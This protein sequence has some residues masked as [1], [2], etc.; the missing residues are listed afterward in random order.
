MT[1]QK[2]Q[3]VRELIEKLEKNGEVIKC[4]ED[5]IFKSVY[6]DKK[7]EGILSYLIVEF[8]DLEEEEVFGNLSIVDSYEPVNNITNKQNTHDLKVR[9]KNNSIFL[10]A[11]QFNDPKTR[12]RNSAHYHAGIVNQIK[13]N[14]NENSIGKVYQI[15]FDYK[16]PFSDEL[17]SNIMM[18]DMKTHQ[19]DESEKNFQKIK[20]NLSKIRKLRYNDVSKLSK[21]EKI[22]LIM[23]ENKKITLHEIAK[24]DKELEVMVGKLEDLSKDPDVMSYYD[25]QKLEEMGQRLNLE[26]AREEGHR[27]TLIET[28]KKMLNKHM[29]ID[30]IIDI[31]NLTKEEVENLK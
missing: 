8:T 18:M 13:R 31:T 5:P 7:I 30:D 16:V 3:S 25:E 4:I 2:K 15:S 1:K 22:L 21:L 27:T 19:I 6:S 29:S 20:V 17:V 10:E 14:S 26:E 11:N 9:I 23:T 24:G 28:A 12:F